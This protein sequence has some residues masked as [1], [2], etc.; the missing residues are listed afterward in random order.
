MGLES[1]ELIAH[2]EEEFH[3]FFS[4]DEA[5]HIETI[6]DFQEAISRKTPLHGSQDYIEQRLRLIL[7]DEFGVRLEDIR[8]EA[9]IVADLGID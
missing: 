6:G 2:V 3:I 1:V 5:I 9:R 4:D 8:P 7:V